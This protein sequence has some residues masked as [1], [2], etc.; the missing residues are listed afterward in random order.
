MTSKTAYVHDRIVHMGGGEKVLQELIHTY[1]T[2]DSRLFILFSPFRT[3]TVGDQSVTITTALPYYINSIFVFC[4]TRRIPWLSRLLD[5]RN[6]MP[7]YPLLITLLRN[8]IRRYRPDHLVISS[9][10]AAKNIVPP[11]KQPKLAPTVTLYLHSPMQ[12]IRDNYDEYIQKLT[13]FK[14]MMFRR[15][16]GYLRKR[17]KKNRVYDTIFVN[18]TY[19]GHC[20]D[21]LYTL[22]KYTVRYP[23]L[24]EIYHTTP[25]TSTPH[26]YYVYV[27]RLVRFIRETDLIIRLFNAV[28]VPL[29]ILW[30]GPDEAYLKSIAG[31]SII[32]LGHITDLQ[33]KVDVI[34]HAKGSINLAKESCGIATMEALALGVPIFG[35][36]QGGT[37]ELVQE[38][39]GV[40][41]S[42]KHLS[43]L[44]ASFH[45][46]EK[47]VVDRASIKQR[48]LAFYTAHRSG[49]PTAPV[50]N[51]VT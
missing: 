23:T 2:T 8:K 6:L 1:G 46:F 34:K 30:S 35:Y 5:Y 28:Q 18:S 26:N 19:T 33:K 9:F 31:D 43:D 22:K 7:F 12:Y 24:E 39:M 44:I 13:G 40:L 47:N 51:P 3:F 17:D 27:G 11:T 32:F 37:A 36:N 14:L 20:A 50:D 49:V 48:F 16:T 25:A 38:G 4:N 41:N 21:R 15:V 29:L 42:N 10:A 45:H